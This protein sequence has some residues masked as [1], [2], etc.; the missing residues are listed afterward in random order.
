MPPY[1]KWYGDGISLSPMTVNI[2][3]GSLYNPGLADMFIGLTVKYGIPISLLNLEITESAYISEPELMRTAVQ[4]LRRA[5]FVTMMDDFGSGYS[6]LNMLKDIDVDALKLDMQFLANGSL[7]KREKSYWPASSRWPTGWECLSSRKGWKQKNRKKSFTG[8]D[9]NMSR[10]FIMNTL[11]R[12]R[13]TR[14]DIFT[15]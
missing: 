13:N 9:A 11:S 5:G 3:R 2:S 15:G 4:R 14:P 12:S 6:S 10:D 7:T 1:G 8:Q